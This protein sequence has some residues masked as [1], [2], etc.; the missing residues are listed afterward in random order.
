MLSTLFYINSIIGHSISNCPHVNLQHNPIV[1][2]SEYSRASWYVQQQ[3]VNGYQSEND[4]YCVV[5]TYNSDDN[6]HV[7]FFSGKVLTVYNYA[8]QDKVNGIPMGYIKPGTSTPYFNST[9]LCARQP[10]SSEPEK[11]LVA[12]CFLPNF[13]G[14]PYWI[15]AVGPN[16]TNYE[17]AIVIGG[18]PTE[19]I[20]NYTCT[21]KSTGF[22]G[23]GLWIFSRNRTLSQDKLKVVHEILDY[24]NIS[25][26]K[27]LNVSQK[28]CNY[29]GAFLK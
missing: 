19:R 12:P 21:T 3:Q 29:I 7:P 9:T 6:S 10:N 17:W 26:L 15:L 24:H 2:I 5:A 14:G 18:Q 22:N 8:N 20:D 28:G 16:T 1:N 23:S 27:L 11:L 25:K 13:L 4:L